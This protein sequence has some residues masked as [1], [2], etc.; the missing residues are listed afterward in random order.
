VLSKSDI[1]GSLLREESGEP[2]DITTPPY[3]RERAGLGKM[4]IRRV[5]AVSDRVRALLSDLAPEVVAAAEDAFERVIYVPV[6]AIGTSPVLDPA[7][8][9]LKVPVSRIAPRWVSVPFLYT[10]AR[11]SSHL[12]ANDRGDAGE[13]IGSAST[14]LDAD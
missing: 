2:V 10:L 13:S 6:S 11:W 5:D 3:W 7:S 4:G 12:V 1:W 14:D 8:G 9:L